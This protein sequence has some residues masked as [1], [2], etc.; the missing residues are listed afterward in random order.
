MSEDDNGS[1]SC[2]CKMIEWT[3]STICVSLSVNKNALY[4]IVKMVKSTLERHD[5]KKKRKKNA[6]ESIFIEARYTLCTR[7]QTIEKHTLSAVAIRF[8]DAWI[9][10]VDLF[11]TV[12]FYYI[13]SIRRLMHTIVFA[14]RFDV[15][16]HLFSHFFL[17][18]LWFEWRDDEILVDRRRSWIFIPY[19]ATR[20]IKYNKIFGNICYSFTIPFLRSLNR[21]NNIV[22]IHGT[23]N[24]IFTLVD[25]ATRQ[26]NL[27]W[28]NIF[29]STD[30]RSLIKSV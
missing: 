11:F 7:V 29:D 20:T 3:F 21:I 8:G 12:A 13:A 28:F 30:A 26:Y 14:K 25:D 10:F 1:H 2:M 5:T 17:S 24:S 15:L 6:T 27:T 22:F 9:S 18:C 19:Y 16:L 23:T 4:S